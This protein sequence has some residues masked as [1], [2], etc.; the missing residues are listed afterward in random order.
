M[1]SEAVKPAIREFAKI[2][3]E[4]SRYLYCR[5]CAASGHICPA[6]NPLSKKDPTIAL[7]FG[8]VP[9][10]LSLCGLGQMYVGRVKRGLAFL[11]LGW[12]FAILNFVG[13]IF[14]VGLCITTP[15]TFVFII[16]QAYDAYKLAKQYN[17]YLDKTGKPPW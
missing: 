5:D 6:I 10:L 13:L 4:V 11:F 9:I 12:I 8:L 1:Q 16:W 7:L 14:V 2:V 3:V 17:D 15:L